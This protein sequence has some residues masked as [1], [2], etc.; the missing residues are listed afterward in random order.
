MTKR[1][2]FLTGLVTA[3]VGAA[4]AGTGLGAQAALPKP[5]DVRPGVIDPRRKDAFPDVIVTDQHGVH[6]RLY[7]DLI[8][9]RV[10]MLNF[11]SIR[12]EINYPVTLNLSRVAGLLG[13]RLGRD[14]HMYSIT[15]DP[16]HD[17]PARLKEFAQVFG[18]PENGWL[19]LTSSQTETVALATRMYRHSHSRVGK[20]T[21]GIQFCT[22]QGNADVVF[23]GNGAVGL[24]GAFP[25][26]IQ[27]ED[28][29]E[30]ITWVMPSAGGAGGVPRRA[31]PRRVD[32][33]G[34]RSSNREA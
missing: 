30:R 9:G 31:G 13:D 3:G 4:A 1:R 26:L 17:T 27:P 23:Y 28:A 22:P 25:G 6:H 20:G 8:E 33:P 16:A 7:D 29:A 12:N 5:E 18:A 2:E 34:P 14:V 19:F 24:W 11:M 32:A 21:A 15:K 10:V